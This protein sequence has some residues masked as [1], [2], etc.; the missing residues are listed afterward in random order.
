[1]KRNYNGVSKGKAIPL[2][3]VKPGMVFRIVSDKLHPVV[4]WLFWCNGDGSYSTDCGYTK[5]VPKPG[6]S[7]HDHWKDG[8]HN[9]AMVINSF[10]KRAI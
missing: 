2:T 10:D 4:L 1:M 7:G 6:W 8:A 5:Q 9:K 3:E